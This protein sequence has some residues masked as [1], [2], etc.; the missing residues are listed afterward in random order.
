MQRPGGRLRGGLGQLAAGLKLLA[1]LADMARRAIGT[2]GDHAVGL[3][4]A[5]L[6]LELEQRLAPGGP[7]VTVRADGRLLDGLLAL[8]VQT[9][10]LSTGLRPALG[11]AW[12]GG[13]ACGVAHRHLAAR[14]GPAAGA[15]RASARGVLGGCGLRHELPP[16]SSAAFA[17]AAC[18]W[19]NCAKTLQM[20]GFHGPAGTYILADAEM[21]ANQAFS[22]K[23]GR[24]HASVT[25]LDRSNRY[26]YRRRA[27]P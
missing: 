2:L 13:T 25:Q 9:E 27:R 20:P 8:T 21:P 14:A 1:D 15:G 3:L 6:E 11:P 17:K 18:G 4:G 16:R 7:A 22:A 23:I 10:P 26:E 24:F 5:A 12:G 19:K